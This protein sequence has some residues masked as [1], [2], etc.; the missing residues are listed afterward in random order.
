MEPL[1]R[2]IGPGAIAGECE[3]LNDQP[4][5]NALDHRYSEISPA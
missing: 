5:A 4:S 2:S 1:L 3:S